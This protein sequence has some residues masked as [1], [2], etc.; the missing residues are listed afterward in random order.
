METYIKRAQK[1]N[2]FIIFAFCL[3]LEMT[4]FMNGGLSYAMEAGV[5]IGSTA[6]LVLVIY[7]LKMNYQVKGFIMCMI[8]ALASL[9]LSIVNGGVTRMFNVYILGVILMGIYFKKKLVILYG[10]VFAGLMVL[11][12]LVYPEGLLGTETGLG[13]FFPRVAVYVCIVAVVTVITGWGDQYVND[14]KKEGIQ[15]MKSNEHLDSLLKNLELTTNQVSTSVQECNREMDTVEQAAI[16]VAKSMQEVSKTTE[17]SAESLATI[18]EVANLSSDNMKAS[19]S[20]MMSVEA[21]LGL[22]K[23]DL[24]QGQVN[25]NSIA[26]QMSKISEAMNLS[27]TTVSNLSQ[28]MTTITKALE[29]ITAI[30]EQTNLLALNAAIEAARAGEH[31]RGFSV[32]AEEVR[33]LAE[34]STRQAEGIQVI[35]DQVMSASSDAKREVTLGKQAVDAGN[36]GVHSL[37]EVFANIQSSF[38]SSYDKIVNEMDVIKE[39]DRK[40]S[41][42]QAQL[43]SVS[44]ASE[45]NAAVTEEVLAQAQMQEHVANKVNLMLDDI[46]RMSKDLNDQTHL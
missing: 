32:V 12:Y 3:V 25:V 42:I 35:T 39:T 23:E 27:Y 16:N 31:G 37:L 18:N 7:F 17:D 34:E 20:T 29:G 8:P 19:L 21:A 5:A 11:V 13:E 44:A 30:A 24:T 10:S 6:I 2:L 14:A 46:E 36:Q 28:S 33:K 43:E 1:F 15:A 9:G 22:T 45:E 26:G 40:F 38:V 41:T 4:A